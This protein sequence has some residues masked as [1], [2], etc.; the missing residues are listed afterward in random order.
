MTYPNQQRMRKAAILVTSLEGP[1]AERIR[2]GLSPA[3]TAALEKAIDQ[4]GP[5]D[6]EEQRDVLD[7]FRFSAAAA[8]KVS[9]GVEADWSSKETAVNSLAR[10][11]LILATAFCTPFPR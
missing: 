5:V 4:L 11:P 6:P 1:W 9:G 10:I 8:A 3:D 7:E 2:K